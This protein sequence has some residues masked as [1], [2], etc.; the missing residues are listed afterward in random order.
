MVRCKIGVTDDIQKKSK[1]IH[2]TNYNEYQWKIEL[3]EEF[4]IENLFTYYDN[5]P[6]WGRPYSLDGIDNFF[7]NIFPDRTNEEITKNMAQQFFKQY[8][9]SVIEQNT[10]LVAILEKK[11]IERTE[12]QK[13]ERLKRR[14]ERLENLSEEE[15]KKE[16]E[17]LNK[18]SEKESLEK[19]SEEDYPYDD[20]EE[21]KERKLEEKADLNRMCTSIKYK[22]Y[23]ILLN[24]GYTIKFEEK[25][26]H[27]TVKV[28][29][30]EKVIKVVIQ[31]NSDL[32]DKSSYL[33]NK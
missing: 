26:Q 22:L 25:N 27:Q 7:E 1:K 18:L 6:S 11:E 12:R 29:K 10:K 5:R 23:K 17:S 8:I 21:K 3:N 4:E 28:V 33:T 20:D 30:N 13:K 2:Q 9:I 32:Y 14:K 31:Y 19:L 15:R 24:G 16:E